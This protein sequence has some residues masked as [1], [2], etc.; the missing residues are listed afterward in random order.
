M[1]NRRSKYSGKAKNIANFIIKFEVLV[2]KVKTNNMYVIFLLKNVRTNII[3]M[4]LEYSLMIV[5]EM[6]KEWKVGG[7]VV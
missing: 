1:P 7:V 5:L 6:L 2:M 3:K 4:I